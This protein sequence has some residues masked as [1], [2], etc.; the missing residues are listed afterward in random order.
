MDL[1]AVRSALAGR[2]EPDVDR[3]GYKKA[4]VLVAICGE[5]PE[6]IMTRK[7]RGMR[8]HA[9]EISFP[10]GKPDAGDADLLDTALREAREEVGLEVSRG[11]VTGQLGSVVTLNSGFVILPFVA[12][13][14]DVPEMEANGEVEQIL[15]MPLGPLLETMRRDPDPSHHRLAAMYEFE[16]LGDVVWG[17]SA[18]ILKQVRDLL[19]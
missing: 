4:S 3:A 17:A 13:L 7:P 2:I 16:Y 18:R 6:V 12:V 15:C 10:G 11:Q 19:A 5:T 14:D 1:D 8:F 9:G